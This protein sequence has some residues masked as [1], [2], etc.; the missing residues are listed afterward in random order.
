MRESVASGLAHPGV[1][2]APYPRSLQPDERL[3]Q[4]FLAPELVSKLKPFRGTT[5]VATE[6]AK[7]FVRR[8]NPLAQQHMDLVAATVKNR[9]AHALCVENL[10]PWKPGAHGEGTKHSDHL[11]IGHYV[12][13]PAAGRWYLIARHGRGI[14]APQ[15]RPY[16]NRKTAGQRVREI[17]EQL[18][19][20][21][22]SIHESTVPKTWRQESIE[23]VSG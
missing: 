13:D 4:E 10:P 12:L 3:L 22:Y 7:E 18:E 1:I 19:D 2:E 20:G 17:V 8:E 5:S 15:H 11:A 23:A 21:R 6:L 9:V 14:Y 16:A